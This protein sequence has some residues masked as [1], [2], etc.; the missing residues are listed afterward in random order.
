MKWF[1]H[2]SDMRNDHFIR[3]L[4]YQYGNEGYAVWCLILEMYAENCGHEPGGKVVFDV[5]VFRKE[6]GISAKKVELFLNFFQTFSKLLFNFSEKKLEIQIPRM[7]S[8]KDNHTKNLQVTGKL[9]APKKKKKEEEVRINNPLPPKG[10]S[11][12]FEKFWSSYPTKVGK[13]AVKRAWERKKLSARLDEILAGLEK[14]RTTEKWTKGYIP[15]PLTFINQ[16]RW[17]DEASTLQGIETPKKPDGV[18]L[19]ESNKFVSRAK[20]WDVRNGSDYVYIPKGLDGF[21]ALENKTTGERIPVSQYKPI[22][23]NGVF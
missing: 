5:D 8:L 2:M 18:L 10:D 11:Q 17:N 23:G 22:T 6:L 20:S 16:E 13:A 4:R 3:S 1:K 9:L 21:D 12:S 15:N 7:A 14:Q 19:I